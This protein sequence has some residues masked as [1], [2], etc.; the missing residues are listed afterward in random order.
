MSS[1][2]SGG[3]LRFLE[4]RIAGILALCRS[5]NLWCFGVEEGEE[6]FKAS[7]WKLSLVE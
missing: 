6:E 3:G 4:V 7:S 2:P 1:N 5:E